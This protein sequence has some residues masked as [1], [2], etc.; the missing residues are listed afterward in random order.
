MISIKPIRAYSS[1]NI[2]IMPGNCTL[3]M[4]RVRS[5]VRDSYQRTGTS[6]VFDILGAQKVLG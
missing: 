6:G 5:R 1:K 4:A 3:G 2:D